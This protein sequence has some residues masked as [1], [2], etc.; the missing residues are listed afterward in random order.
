M[1]GPQCDR[2]KMVHIGR[3]DTTVGACAR[4]GN[5]AVGL[6]C[7]W[8]RESG[9][10]KDMLLP[11]VKRAHDET[12]TFLDGPK[13]R[14]PAYAYGSGQMHTDPREVVPDPDSPPAEDPDAQYKCWVLYSNGVKVPR[15]G[16]LSLEDSQAWKGKWDRVDPTD[17]H[18][19]EKVDTTPPAE[20]PDAMYRL[21]WQNVV[22]TRVNRGGNNFT[23]AVAREWKRLEDLS[24]K[25]SGESYR[26]WYEKVDTETGTE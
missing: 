10:I 16:T 3:I 5:G 20:D 15:Q 8:L 17:K 22:S 12:L 7:G 24:D 6:G 2:C 13:D 4:C 21:C 1:I 19:Y 14:Y 9:Q 26:N 11:R 18:W 23:L 25:N